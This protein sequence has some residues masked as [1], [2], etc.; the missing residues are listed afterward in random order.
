MLPLFLID[1]FPVRQAPLRMFLAVYSW[2]SLATWL[3]CISF[4]RMLCTLHGARLVAKQLTSPERR[5]SSAC[6]REGH[7]P[8]E[9]K[10]LLG[11]AGGV[12][13]GLPS[14]PFLAVCCPAVMT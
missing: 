3:S 13:P 8:P 12:V 9:H 1:D 5:L 7:W 6:L 2:C 4:S 11:G 10:S 14:I